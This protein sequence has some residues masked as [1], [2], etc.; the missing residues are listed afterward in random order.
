[1]ATPGGAN[2]LLVIRENLPGHIEDLESKIAK[3]VAEVVS[4]Q[5]ELATAR[6]LLAV[7]PQNGGKDD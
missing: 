2:P 1:M 3:K 4:L 7:A 5:Q 6:T